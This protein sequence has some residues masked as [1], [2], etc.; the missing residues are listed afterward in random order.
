[1]T[2]RTS[3]ALFTALLLT[4][5]AVA[6]D[7]GYRASSGLI[8]LVPKGTS[9]F[10]GSLG[11]TLSRST[12]YIATAGGAVVRDRLWFFAAGQ[13]DTWQFGSPQ[14]GQAFDG[15]LTAQLGDRNTLG[16]T[17]GRGRDVTTSLPSS[18]LSFRFDSVLSSNT[19]FSANVTRRKGSAPAS[20]FAPFIEP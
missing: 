4:T 7:A 1:M 10:S 5:A 15:K 9:H 18:F 20:P 17:A 3:A 12:G 6:Q 8:S 19:F 11:V 16:A 14:S 13:H 2:K